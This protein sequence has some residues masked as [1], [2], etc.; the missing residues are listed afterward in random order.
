MKRRPGPEGTPRDLFRP[1]LP[2]PLEGGGA[3][4]GGLKAGVGRK[5]EAERLVWSWDSRRPNL[6][7]LPRLR[8]AGVRGTISR[9]KGPQRVGVDRGTEETADRSE[10]RDLKAPP[11]RGGIPGLLFSLVSLF[12]LLPGPILRDGWN[13]PDVSG[14]KGLP[15][16]RGDLGR[17]EPVGLYLS[18]PVLE[19]SRVVPI[20]GRGSGPWRTSPTGGKDDSDRPPGKR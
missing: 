6:R 2:K 13:R 10:P 12:T 15:D 5:V 4:G 20:G 19:S 14:R 7:G 18:L 16:Q 17:A 1:S 3:P 9:G 11:G 8:T